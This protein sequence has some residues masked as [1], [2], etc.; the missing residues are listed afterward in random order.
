LDQRPYIDEVNRTRGQLEQSKASLDQS[1]AQLT[2]AEAQVDNASAN[3]SYQRKRL[4]RSK[5]L[6]PK[7]VLTQEEFDQHE[8]ETLR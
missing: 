7:G 4:E 5:Q 2:Q 3:L 6:R 8:S 1:H